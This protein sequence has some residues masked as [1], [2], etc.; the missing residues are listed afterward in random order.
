MGGYRCGRGNARLRAVFW[1][2]ASVAVRMRENSFRVK[3]ERYMQTDPGSADRKWKAYVAV[4]AKIVRVAYTL[5]RSEA[6][7]RCFPEVLG[8]EKTVALAGGPCVAMVEC[9]SCCSW[10]PLGLT[11]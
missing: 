3:F 2:A 9:H 1:M 6:D 8:T 5:V 10:K 4:A 11:L 7:Y